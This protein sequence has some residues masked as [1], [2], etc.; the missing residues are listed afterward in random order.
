MNIGDIR[1]AS[2]LLDTSFLLDAR[3]NL[4][5]YANFIDSLKGNG[6]AFLGI[7]LVKVEFVRSSDSSSLEMK[8]KYYEGLIETD[9]PI[10]IMTR[11]YVIELMGEY[12]NDLQGV[13]VVD[14]YLAACTKRYEGLFLLTAN[15]K[16][17]PIKVFDRK[18]IVNFGRN[19]DIRTYAFYRYKELQ[20][21]NTS[22]PF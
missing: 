19:K 8:K 14:L 22:I 2:I 7:D 6:N 17:F 16:D 13:S 15:H 11:D 10:D 12:G 1:N 20:T 21:E 4:V 18:V 3:A 9:L 5:E